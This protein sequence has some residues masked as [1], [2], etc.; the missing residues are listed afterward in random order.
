MQESLKTESTSYEARGV[1]PHKPDVK[2][3][4]KNIDQGIFP[5]AFCKAVPDLF[6]KSKEH[7]F[8]SHADG[9]GTKSSLAYLQY[10]KHADTSIFQD[11]A[12]DSLVMN[13]DDLLCVGAVGPFILSNTIGRNSK[14]IGAEIL[15]DTIEGYAKVSQ[16][17]LEYGIEI[18]ECG[19]ETADV[20][21]LVRTIII[22]STLSTRMKRSDFIDCSNVKPNQSIVGFASF[23]KATYED[24][25]N[26]GI[27]TNGFTTA[28]HELLNSSYRDKYPET[29]SP[30]IYDLA[31]NGNFD[32]D[33]PLPNTNMT[34]G[35]AL[36][37]PTRT[38]AP[39]MKKVL[40]GY[41]DN[42]SAIFHN[43]GGAQT[44]C[45]AFGTN[46]KYIKDNLFP[47]PPIFKFIK[48]HANLSLYELYRVLNMGHRFE[49]VCDHDVA[50][51][52]ISIS[53]EFNVDA[54]IVGRTESNPEGTTL[55]IKTEEGVIEY[56][57]PE[58]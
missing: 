54:R 24:K 52:I 56:S 3:A 23:G 22:D 6:T 29:F 1:S 27:G 31:Y 40:E 43:S 58:E 10:K 18:V 8:L 4:L 13:L 9:A 36:L 51:E 55:V 48:E 39:I 14:K 42:I 46:I 15:K 25:E 44:K 38:Y 50:N 37:S 30:E 26:S 17:M 21:D 47:E 49:V 16:K 32:M 33:E 7:C 12:Q 41:K 45:L 19:G 20:G 11:I 5:K 35:E 34:V 28:R 2:Y 53:K 57:R